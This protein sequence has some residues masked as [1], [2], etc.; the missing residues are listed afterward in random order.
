MFKFEKDKNGISFA[1]MKEKITLLFSGISHLLFPNIC[2]SCSCELGISEESLCH[3][4][5]AKL[6]FT[7][8]EG[9][10][11]PTSL[12]K[13]FWGRVLIK[14]TY[15]L[16]FFEQ[17]KPS[18]KILHSLKYQ[19]KG[20]LG[21]LFGR[22]IGERMKKNDLMG[23]LQ[24]LIPVPLHPKKEFAR[25][26]NQSEKIALGISKLLAIPIL[27]KSIKKIKHTE[28]Q[29]KKDRFQRWENVNT[30]F[31]AKQAIIP[32]Q[33]IAIVD[34]VVTTGATIEALALELLSNN[35]DLQISII[36]LAIAK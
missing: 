4:C 19:N 32:F 17:D 3:F 23:N 22:I 1:K 7:Y 20:N 36:S 16:F 27:K 13:I 34:D 14:D 10:N 33:H 30:I 15:A 11:E 18:Q 6:S 24:A 25:G 21:V 8:F 26:Y 12:D 31:G 29:T 2:L 5:F 9:A 28:S 35:P